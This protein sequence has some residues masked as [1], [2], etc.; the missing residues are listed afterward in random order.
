VLHGNNQKGDYFMF[1]V[2]KWLPCVAALAV[3]V[4]L[5]TAGPARAGIEL[6]LTDVT[7]NQTVNGAV[8]GNSALYSGA[9][10]AFNVGITVGLSNSPGGTNAVTQQGSLFI[11]NTSNSAQTRLCCKS[12]DSGTLGKPGNYPALPTCLFEE[13][14]NKAPRPCKS[15]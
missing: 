2:A 12:P 13:F 7:T 8:I 11:T 14:C 5:G 3:V 4:L 15:W 9:V 10:G 1:R 6:V